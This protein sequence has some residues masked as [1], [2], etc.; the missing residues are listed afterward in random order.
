MLEEGIEPSGGSLVH[1]GLPRP[2]PSNKRP[3]QWLDTTSEGKVRVALN[4][5]LIVMSSLIQDKLPP[6]HQDVKII[7]PFWT[8]GYSDCALRVQK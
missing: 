6:S 7:R 4:T 5:E 2:P 1:R 8:R 3:E